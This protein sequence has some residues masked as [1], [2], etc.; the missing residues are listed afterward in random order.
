MKFVSIL[1]QKAIIEST[2]VNYGKSMDEFERQEILFGKL[3][4]ERFRKM[5][6]D[7]ILGKI[8]DRIDE[9]HKR[10]FNKENFCRV[11]VNYKLFN[12]GLSEF[13]LFDFINALLPDFRYKN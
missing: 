4:P 13:L 2:T 8:K 1:L 6:Y 5:F 10:I 3:L 11:N 7:P 9:E 12:S